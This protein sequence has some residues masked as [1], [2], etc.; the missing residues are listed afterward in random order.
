MLARIFRPAKT[1]M[2]SGRGKPGVW[3]LEFE[4]SAPRGIEPLMG[5][6]SGKDTRSGQV[7]LEFDTREEAVAYCERDG[8]PYQVVDAKAAPPVPKAYSDNFAFRRRFPWTH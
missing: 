7:T 1:S 6:T 2:Q 5:W 8:I 4:P 3:R